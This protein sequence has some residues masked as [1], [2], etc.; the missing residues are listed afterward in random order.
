MK[1]EMKL[2]SDPFNKIKTGTKTIELRLYDEK[3]RQLKIN[4]QI[5]FTNRITLD[6]VLVNRENIS[7]YPNF[8]ELY[9]HFDKI[10]MGYSSNEKKNFQDMEKYY[11]KIEQKRWGVMAIEI[12]RV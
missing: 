5:E 3:R 4:D 11:S 2:H 9:K 7:I 1:H 10:A 8:K 6:K 12:K